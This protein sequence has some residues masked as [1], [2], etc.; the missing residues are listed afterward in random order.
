MYH[1]ALLPNPNLILPKWS[2]KFILTGGTGVSLFFL[3]SAFTMCLTMDNHRCSIKEVVSFYSRR[4]FRIAPLF[5]IWIFLSCIRDWYMWNYIHSIKEFLL[6]FF[7]AFN[8]LPSYQDGIVWAGW[9]IGVEMI[10]YLVFP[11]IFLFVNTT[12]KSIVFLLGSVFLAFFFKYLTFT[13]PY[14]KK[15]LNGFYH[16]SFIH[17]LPLFA[18]GMACYFIYKA[19][20]RDKKNH[21]QTGHFLITSGII[22]YFLFINGLLKIPF[23]SLYFQG[24]VYSIIILGLSISQ[25]KILVNRIT[26][27]LGKISYS[28]YL[29]HPT[30]IIFLIPIVLLVYK[31]PFSVTVKFY[32][33]YAIVISTVFTISYFSYKFIE[34]PG[35]NAGRQLLS[36]FMS[37]NTDK[38]PTKDTTQKITISQI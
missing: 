12:R 21:K 17:N 14:S 8:F 9:T 20:I 35:I 15:I 1:L 19:N 6:S 32:A 25:P 5:Y 30:I 3:L 4:F 31:L 11:F 37:T 28:I 16:H 38:S 22:L 29:N 26:T 36:F 24:I 18:F 7:F 23:D 33:S 13:L 10:F 34:S 27:F 2:S